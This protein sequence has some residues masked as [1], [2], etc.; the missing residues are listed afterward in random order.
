MK[1]AE[2]RIGLEFHTATGAWRCTDVGTRVVT[3]LQLGHPDPTVY[4]GPPYPVAEIAFDEDSQD[5]ASLR[6]QKL[7]VIGVLD[8][9]TMKYRAVASAE[10]L[11]REVDRLRH[12]CTEAYHFA[13]AVGAPG[14][15][16]DALW[17]ASDAKPP[18]RDTFLPVSSN[19]RSHTESS[20]SRREKSLAERLM[21][22][23]D[24]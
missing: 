24:R 3:A 17:A 13:A 20:V 14:R 5:A 6:P 23:A 15:L 7:V 4:E 16:L 8:S 19:E 10:A 11:K 1:H 2:F 18:V 9:Q 22:G 21:A 12:V